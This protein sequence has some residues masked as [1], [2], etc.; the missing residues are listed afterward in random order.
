MSAVLEFDREFEPD[1]GALTPISEIKAE[2]IRRGW[3]NFEIS[4]DTDKD[5]LIVRRLPRRHFS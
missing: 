3:T 4:F 5:K 1:M 2:V